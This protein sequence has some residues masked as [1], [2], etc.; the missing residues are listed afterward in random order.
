MAR[1]HVQTLTGVQ[2]VTP[3]RGVWGV[4][5]THES[6]MKHGDARMMHA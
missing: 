3:C 6:R 4:A 2:G 5:V 1:V